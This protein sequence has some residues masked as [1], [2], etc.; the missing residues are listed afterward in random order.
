MVQMNILTVNSF[1]YLL[2]IFYSIYKV[3]SCNII[4]LK[5]VTEVGNKA[6]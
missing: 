1:V 5:L 4:E 3:E 2:H 6:Q